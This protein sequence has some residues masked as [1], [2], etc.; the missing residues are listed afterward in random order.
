MLS[1]VLPALERALPGQMALV[2]SVRVGQDD[3]WGVMLAP[4]TEDGAVAA[5]LV[6]VREQGSFDDG[7]LATLEG[8]CALLSLRSPTQPPRS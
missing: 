8:A 5:Y 4:V 6:L 7:A 2:S 1:C 3:R